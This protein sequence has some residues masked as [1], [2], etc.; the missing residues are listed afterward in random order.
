MWHIIYRKY[1]MITIYITLALLVTFSGVFYYFATVSDSVETIVIDGG[2]IY[3]QPKNATDYQK[4]LF[5]ELSETLNSAEATGS[6]KAAI[7]VE[8]FIASFYTWTNKLGSYDVGG[9]QYV[10]APNTLYIQTEAKAFFYKDLSYYQDTYGS[11]NL[12][13][14]DSVTIKYVDF[15][16]KYEIDGVEY[17]SYY[18]AAKWTYLP[19]DE[20]DNS[21]YQTQGYFSVINRDGRYEIYR[22]YLE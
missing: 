1:E 10:Y 7:V 19:N 15:E 6:E 21:E 18:V 17:M 14:V 13:Q 4:E 22:Y 9:L 20:F 11:E 12:L 16:K 8:N 5:A 2:G 3:T